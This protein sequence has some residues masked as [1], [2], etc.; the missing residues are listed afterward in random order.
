M[1]SPPDNPQ[2]VD[3]LYPGANP[4]S[5][6]INYINYKNNIYQNN[7]QLEESSK[8]P[9]KASPKIII[10]LSIFLILVV[11][12]DTILQILDGF[13]PFVLVDD[14]LLLCIA[15]IYLVFTYKKISFQQ[16]AIAINTIFVFIVGVLLKGIGIS[17]LNN[18]D[19]ITIYLILMGIRIF[20]NFFC[21][22]PTFSVKSRIHS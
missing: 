13:N 16:R 8:G 18:D 22:P 20:S 11:L 15:I 5:P 6:L 2:Q 7:E 9:K 4:Y 19:N 3:P 12:A 21:I 17:K 10:G 1:L 14:V